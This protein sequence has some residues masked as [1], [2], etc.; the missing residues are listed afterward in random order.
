MY[1]YPVTEGAR[2]ESK[3]WQGQPVTALLWIDSAQST[4]R[5]RFNRCTSYFTMLTFRGTFA[6][7]ILV[8]KVRFHFFWHCFFQFLSNCLWPWCEALVSFETKYCYSILKYL[9]PNVS[10]TPIMTMGCRQRL[11]PSVVQLKGKH[12]HKTHCR[13][14]L[15]DTFRAT[16]ALPQCSTWELPVSI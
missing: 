1:T 4:F 12:C 7:Q 14:G 5:I 15:V 11:H 13:I 2:E 10:T 9:C 16:L 8:R 6:K 3:Q